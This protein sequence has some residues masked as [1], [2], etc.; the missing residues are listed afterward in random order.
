[1]HREKNDLLL[2]LSFY[3]FFNL[4]KILILGNHLWI[5]L[6]DPKRKSL[7]VP[8]Q[9]GSRRPVGA[10]GPPPSP[11]TALQEARCLQAGLGCLGVGVGLGNPSE[12]FLRRCGRQANPAGAVHRARFIALC[13]GAVRPQE[14]G[15]PMQMHQRVPAGGKGRHAPCTPGQAHSAQAMHGRSPHFL[16]WLGGFAAYRPRSRSRVRFKTSIQQS[17]PL[18]C[19]CFCAGDRFGSAPSA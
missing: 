13:A 17:P 5:T 2:T 15:Y 6:N 12:G 3:S 11:K 1:M 9:A 4:E 14:L 19:H 10:C 7:Q 18:F 8:P 16:G